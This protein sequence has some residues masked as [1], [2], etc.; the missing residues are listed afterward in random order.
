MSRQPPAQQPPP[1]V[2]L[3]V[4]YGKT[5]P[6]RFA[7]HRDFARAFERALRR[8]E[9]PMAYSSGFSPHPRLSY[10]NPAPTGVESVAEY[11]VIGLREVA[12]PADVRTRLG[13]VMPGGFPI[14]EVTGYDPAQ[15]FDASLWEVRVGGTTVE[16]LET[17]VARFLEAEEVPVGRETKT[18]WRTFDARGPVES[19][20]VGNRALGPQE[21]S[22]LSNPADRT[23]T[24]I[25]HH[26][27]P[28]VRP[29]D[30]V[31]GLGTL[32]TIGPTVLITRLAQADS[33]TLRT[34][35]I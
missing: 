33:T 25:I 20:V 23:L 31:A 24:M 1:V 8:A 29:D 11:L 13:A 35:L 10:I 22:P 15:S 4:R 6:A 7:S 17:A 28:L 2:K 27:T 34:V 19:L 18:G 14:V 26:T 3:L 9:L 21:P 5:G 12:D 32:G 16:A 30:V